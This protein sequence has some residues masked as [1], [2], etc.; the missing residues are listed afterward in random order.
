M[1]KIDIMMPTYCYDCPCHNGETGRCNITGASV[2]GKRPV[3]CPLQEG[4]ATAEAAPDSPG[5]LLVMD[6][7]DAIAR[8]QDHNRVHQQ[9]EHGAFYITEALDMAVVALGKQIPKKIKII[10]DYDF[11]PA[12]NFR[13]GS[14]AIRRKLRHWH[15]D[16]CEKCGQRLDWESGN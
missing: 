6:A 13:Y 9:K 2:F 5:G 10:D 12:C 16:F 1:V 11:C 14:D 15:K 3:D 7:S 4:D 8:I